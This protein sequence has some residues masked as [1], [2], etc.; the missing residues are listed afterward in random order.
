MDQRHF[1]ALGL[2]YWVA[3]CGASVF[4]ANLGDF[5]AHNLGRG[6][7]GGLPILAIALAFTLIGGRLDQAP[8]EAYY[9]AAI[10][11]I[12][13]AATNCADFATI[14]FALPRSRVIVILTLALIVVVAIW[15]FAR[16]WST[17][18]KILRA[19]SGYWISMFL[20]GTLGTVI[21]DFFSYNLHLG[22][23]VSSLALSAALAALFL[24]GARGLLWVLPFYWLTVVMIRAAGTVVGDYLAA[25]DLLGLKASTLITGII[26]VGILWLWKDAAKSIQ[27]AAEQNLA[28]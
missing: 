15:Y 2:R 5:F 18:V 4:G 22:D 23:A 25:D 9:W 21:G 27:K 8:R 24:I 7:A 11:V 12:R 28:E 10:V 1:P 16:Q 6:H 17:K 20:A 3:L 19:D 13:T 14:D 26:F